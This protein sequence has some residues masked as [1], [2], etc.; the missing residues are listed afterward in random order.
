MRRN[1]EIDRSD[2]EA[3]DY[4]SSYSPTKSP[5]FDPRERLVFR[6]LPRQYTP[7]DAF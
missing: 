6:D 1:H 7:R 3:A 2:G 5:G 4:K